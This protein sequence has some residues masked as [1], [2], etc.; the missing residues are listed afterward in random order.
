MRCR[1]EYLFAQPENAE[2]TSRSPVLDTFQS[3]RYFGIYW[4]AQCL[5]EPYRPTNCRVL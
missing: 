5:C 1:V 2:Q 4:Y 3:D